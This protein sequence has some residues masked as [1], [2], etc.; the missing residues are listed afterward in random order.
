MPPCEGFL[1]SLGY[2]ARPFMLWKPPLWQVYRPPPRT[3]SR[4]PLRQVLRSKKSRNRATPFSGK[5]RVVL[6]SRRR[7]RGSLPD[8]VLAPLRETLAGS[9]Y[10]PPVRI[11]DV[12]HCVRQH[13]GIEPGN[14]SGSVAHPQASTVAGWAAHSRG[15]AEIASEEGRHTD[16]GRHSDRDL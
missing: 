1:C 16:H 4:I 11:R 12:P 6:A 9:R 14:F 15:R 5:A 13:Y 8:A 7:S 3:F 2:A 10:V